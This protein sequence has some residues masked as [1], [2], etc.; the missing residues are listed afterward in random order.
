MYVRTHVC[1]HVF[2]N[3]TRP[4]VETEARFLDPKNITRK[5]AM[6]T[7]S[8][9]STGEAEG[10]SVGVRVVVKMLSRIVVKMLSRI[11]VKMLSRIVVK[12]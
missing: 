11:V 9:G 1:T 4:K 10:V 3:V 2:P 6:S 5:P 7:E 12:M 8:I